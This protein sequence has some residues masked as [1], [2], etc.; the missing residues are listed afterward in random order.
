M[1]PT[2]PEEVLETA[3]DEPE[4]K[5]AST[6]DNPDVD[7]AAGVE[8]AAMAAQDAWQITEYGYHDDPEHDSEE[9]VSDPLQIDKLLDESRTTIWATKGISKIR[10]VVR[11]LTSTEMAVFL[12]TLFGIS[13]YLDEA[14]NLTREERMIAA[15][16]KMEEVGAHTLYNNI[17][18][19]TEAAIEEPL[20]IKAEML[21]NWP[22]ELVNKLT[23]AATGGAFGDTAQIRFL[24]DLDARRNILRADNLGQDSG[25][26]RNVANGDSEEV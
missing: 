5:D 23:N 25:E 18:L 21:P 15:E 2:D 14:N 7:N 9:L 3:E 12:E 10:F 8:A 24:K 22:E 19:A 20:G 17:L 1:T 13:A 11:K 6:G 26:I 16:Q 4:E